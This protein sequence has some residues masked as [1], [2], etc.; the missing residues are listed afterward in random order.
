[1]A[2]LRLVATV[3][4]MTP[5]VNYAIAFGIR[6]SDRLSIVSNDSFLLLLLGFHRR[7]MEATMTIQLKVFIN[8]TPSLNEVQFLLRIF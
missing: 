4:C 1:M 5:A 6:I 7:V 8:D 3:C 2:S